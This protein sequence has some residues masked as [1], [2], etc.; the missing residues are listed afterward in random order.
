[1]KKELMKK[2]KMPGKA[3]D[4]NLEMGEE[5]SDLDNVDASAASD[6]FN[7]E[8][9]ESEAGAID[10]TPVKDEDLEKEMEKRGYKVEKM[11][12]EQSEGEAPVDSGPD[13]GSMPY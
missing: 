12:D 4:P 5:A 11:A 6:E 13:S 2:L 10:L 8:S 3:S 9:G 7:P 1:M